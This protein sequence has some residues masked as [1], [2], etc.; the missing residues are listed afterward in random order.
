MGC[1]IGGALAHAGC[2]VVMVGRDRVRD[3]IATHGIN[4]VDMQGRRTTTRAAR[5]VTSAAAL[6]DRDVVLCCVKSAQ[7]ASV[8]EELAGILPP[9]TV[10]VSMQNGVGNA[11]TLRA[12]LKQEVLGGIVGFNV[13]SRGDGVFR[14]A[15]SGQLV[16]EDR[17]VAGELRDALTRTGFDVKWI[18]DIEPV[19]WAKLVMNLNN[20]ISALSG[21]PTRDIV[22]DAK[23]RRVL[24][25]IVGEAL[26]VMKAAGIRAGRLG[27]FPVTWFP[28]I[29]SIPTPIL[30]V[31]ARAQLDIDPE[32]RSS[33]WE[34]LT[35][36]RLTEVEFLNGEIVRLAESRGI[37]APMNRRIVKLV[38]DAEA[39]AQGSPHMSADSLWH[40]IA[41]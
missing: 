34:D 18:R 9:R 22:F 36:R 40:A 29:V 15:T 7:T 19:Q 2:D 3:E 23:Y 39:A 26:R 8:G 33:M 5:F 17:G 28:L 41:G 32:A 10:V 21:A 30:R 37:D 25:G 31:V 12:K 1:Y 4:L 16:I 6:D 14:Q 27:A 13:L 38:H 11:A 20:A 24:G 35:R